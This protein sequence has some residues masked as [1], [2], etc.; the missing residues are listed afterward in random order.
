MGSEMRQ[1]AHNKDCERDN[2]SIQCVY[3]VKVVYSMFVKVFSFKKA[4]PSREPSTHTARINQ[5]VCCQMLHL[6]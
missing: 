1:R 2:I 5:F 4:C 3:Y 6:M